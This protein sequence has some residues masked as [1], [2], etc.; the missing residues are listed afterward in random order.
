MEAES[1]AHT[2]RFGDF[3]LDVGAHELHLHGERIRLERRPFDLLV[4]LVTRAGLL[5]TRL[6]MPAVRAP[7]RPQGNSMTV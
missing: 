1:R 2:Y 7:G 4:L 6:I 5:V 3:T